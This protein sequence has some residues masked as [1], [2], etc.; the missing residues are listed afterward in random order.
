MWLSWLSVYTLVLVWSV[1]R[2]A[3]LYT[4]FLEVFP[5]LVG[6]VVLLL[7]RRSFPLTGLAYVLVLVH[8]II[9][10]VGGH[11]TYAEVPLF[12][13]IS[14][15][16]DLGRNNYDK[17]GHFAQGFVPAILAR[18]ILIRNAVVNG[19]GWLNFL[20]LCFCLALSACYEIIEW[21]VALLSAEAADSFL[22]TQG[23]VWDTQ[24]DMGW[25]LLGAL[26]S[27]LVLGR[28]HDRQLQ[29]VMASNAR[30]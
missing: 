9:L 3:D 11:Y 4:W 19:R 2:P 1:I 18:E 29:A 5:A 20:V 14:D 21:L 26:L 17:L 6:L 16:F 24:S 8:C 28:Y 13:W 22:G 25:A 27:L 10:M 15:V 7:T 12:D 30:G 23:Y